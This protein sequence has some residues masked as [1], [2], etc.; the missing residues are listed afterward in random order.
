MAHPTL[1]DVAAV[2]LP[3]R[4]RLAAGAAILAAALLAKIAGPAVIVSSDLSAAWKTGLT[5]ALFIIV[6]KILVISI[7][8]LLGKS[9]FAYLK[10]VVYTGVARVTAPLAP[11]RQVSPARYRVGLVILTLALAEALFMPYLE[12]AFPGL[13]KRH[14]AWDWI[15]DGALVLGI[16]VLGGDFWDKLRALYVHGAVVQFPPGRA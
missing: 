5:A 4:S 10:S 9:G 6:P 2:P 12:S 13:A 7:V 1:T 14:P 16:F 3:S 11:P 8:L 15:S